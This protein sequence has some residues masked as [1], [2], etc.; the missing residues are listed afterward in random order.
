MKAPPEMLKEPTLQDLGLREEG[1][2]PGPAWP[3]WHRVDFE[4]QVEAMGKE[5]GWVGAGWRLDK[6]EEGP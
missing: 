6:E 5:A 4:I 3:I 1:L 2:I